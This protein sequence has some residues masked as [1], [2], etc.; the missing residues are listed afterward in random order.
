M[1][2]ARAN[3]ARARSG[4][5]RAVV[6]GLWWAAL[7]GVLTF[8]AFPFRAVPDSGFWPLAWV[9]L[10]PLL[11]ALRDAGPRRAFFYGWLAGVVTNMGGFWWI[12]EVLRDFG[13]LP[14]AVAWPLTVLNATYQGLQLG[15]F[16]LVLAW[17][18]PRGGGLPGVGT[19]AGAFTALEYVFPMI[20]PWYL[21]NSQNPFPPVTQIA[22]VLGNA[23]VTFTLVLANAVILRVLEAVVARE[24]LRRV[25]SVLG[26][27]VVAGVLLYGLIRIPQVDA[28]VEEA[29]E[30]TVGMVEADIGIWEKEARG[31]EPRE[32]ALT[33]HANLLKHQRMSMDLTERGADLVVWPESSYFPLSDVFGKRLDAFAA[34]VG[35]RGSLA[36]WRDLREEGFQ[37]TVGPSLG[38]GAG[39]LRAV[40]AP[41]EDAV[42]AVGDGGRVVLWDGHQTEQIPIPAVPGGAQPDLHA[43]AATP[44][45]GYRPHADGAPLVVWAAG[46]HGALYRGDTSRLRAVAHDGEGTLRALALSGPRRG[47]AVGDEGTLLVLGEGS[48]RR[49]DLP[50]D[51]DLHGAWAATRDLD[52]VAVGQ[53]GT[54]VRT[55]ADGWTEDPTPTGAT[56]RDVA[57]R[58]REA[59]WIV[60]DE[61][62]VLRSDGP[63]RWAREAFP[64]RVDL[65]SV[66]V[67][68]R[69][70][71]LASDARGG[72]WVRGGDGG[73]SRQEAPGIGPLS[74]LAGLP[75]T[76]MR[77]IPRDARYLY[78]SPLPPPEPSEF[79][80]APQPEM[81]LPEADRG[82]VQR[83]FTAPV[84]FGAITWERRTPG[85]PDSR[86]LLY[87]TAVLLDET[88]RVVG[89]YDK[90]YLL[91]FGEYI[92]FGDTFPVF[93]EWIPES[94]RFEAGHEVKV[95]DWDGKRVGVM[96]CYEDI[97]PEFANRL[98]ARD[99]QLLLNLTNDAWFGRTSEPYLHLALSRMRSVES[100]RTLLRST[101][102]GVSAVID[103]VGRL[104]EQTDLDEPDTVLATVPLMTMD[105][106]Y[107]RVGDLFAQ[108][109][110]AWVTAL[111]VIR[112]LWGRRRSRA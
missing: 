3:R 81:T 72:L 55:A 48:A 2:A 103:P 18:Q 91:V 46:E 51:A 54:V 62:T 77:P 45:P 96:V 6:G 93:Y 73:W 34:G 12:V 85:D 32:Q 97:L 98:A 47:V 68:P 33:L 41:R 31:L 43:V 17:L 13:H 108:V 94:S 4:G 50:T 105:T 110:L 112:R 80:A 26:L 25:Q 52:F 106:L 107:G 89:M 40:V 37:W 11:W 109:L 58:D 66:A 67:A 78:Q 75:W 27:L 86:R 102:T 71:I 29:P 30:M 39:M 61:G 79:L 14:P 63:G 57:G 23:G 19:I 82:A 90:V 22:D 59:V 5:I 101:N 24:R 88:G 87:N 15:L 10:V 74:D 76:R 70:E 44:A 9:C 36:L 8:V 53:G 95:F 60:G 1:S 56:L 28:A 92:P 99:P 21:G 83:G 65:V 84:V 42:V 7:S 64:E 20:F 69:G 104:V 111:V 35:P 49:V 38:E 100:R 16:A